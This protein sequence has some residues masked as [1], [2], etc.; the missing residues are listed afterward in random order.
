L[1]IDPFLEDAKL[2]A[3][4][5][6]QRQHLLL[7]RPTPVAQRRIR[8]NL[9]P[10]GIFWFQDRM[11]VASKKMATLWHI[12]KP[13]GRRGK[14]ALMDIG[15]I[16]SHES[17]KSLPIDLAHNGPLILQSSSSQSGPCGR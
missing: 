9:P 17:K 10:T 7:E 4:N 12:T 5:N 1:L 8:Y 6:A 3:M 15:S 16:R 14:T 11:A 2:C 13:R